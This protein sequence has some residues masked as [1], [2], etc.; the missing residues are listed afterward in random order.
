MKKPNVIFILADDMG[1]GDLGIFGDG[2]SQTPHLDALAGGGVCLSRYYTASP[3]CAPAR[4][5]ILTGRYPHRTGAIDTLEACELDRL[6]LN[7]TTMADVFKQNGYAT[8]MVGKWHLGYFGDEYAPHARGFDEAVYFRGAFSD[9]YD[10]TLEYNGEKH[11]GDGKYLTDVF[12]DEAVGY[13][14]RHKDEPFFLYVAYNAPHF[15]FQCPVEYVERFNHTGRSN[16]TLPTLYGMIACMDRGVGDIIA[17]VRECGVEDDTLIVFTSDNGPQ[18]EYGGERYN[19]HLHGQKGTVYD[20]GLRVPAILRWPGRLAANARIH[21]FM[22]GVDW[23][24]TLFDACGITPPENL[25]L[26]GRSV[27]DIL[28]RKPHEYGK[29]RHWQWNRFTPVSRCNAAIRDGVWK[30]VWPMIPESQIVPKDYAVRWEQELYN[31]GGLIA[32]MKYDDSRRVIPPS[33]PPELYN[34]EDDPLETNDLSGRYPELTARLIEDLDNW[35]AEIE[36]E[37]RAITR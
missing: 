31:G 35:F 16:P 2:S 34:L 1:Y 10:Y 11:K 15:P 3:M 36:T 23:F 13:I 22:H 28:M 33:F 17:A 25:R 14:K 9:Y 5:T 27:L 20:G 30:L 6:S 26:D 8:G 7:E 37:R 32:G 12:T 21:D 4:A 29:Q 18:L 24:P 19:C